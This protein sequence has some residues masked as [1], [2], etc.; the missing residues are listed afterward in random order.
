MKIKDWFN[1]KRA[2]NKNRLEAIET[3]RLEAMES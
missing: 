1:T 2:E 3:H